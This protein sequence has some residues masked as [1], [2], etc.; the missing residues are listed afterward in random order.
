MELDSLFWIV[1]RISKDLRVKAMLNHI[2]TAYHNS[3]LASFHKL[4][5]Q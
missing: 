4:I 3:M 2:T 1:S 5:V